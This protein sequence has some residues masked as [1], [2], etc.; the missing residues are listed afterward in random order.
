[1]TQLRELQA[2]IHIIDP[3]Y[4]CT[5]IDKKIDN[6]IRW[7]KIK[8]GKTFVPNV[9]IYYW[10]KLQCKD[11]VSIRGVSKY[12]LVKH[13]KLYF[14]YGRTALHRGFYLEFD[15]TERLYW[16][17]INHN[18]RYLVGKTKANATK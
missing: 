3:T 4:V 11:R 9:V 6:F 1:M 17:A 14:S 16:R 12:K 15:M 10:Y 18:E 7:C 13:F 8:E 5:P 2:I